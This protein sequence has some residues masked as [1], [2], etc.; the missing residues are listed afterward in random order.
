MTIILFIVIGFIAAAWWA[1]VSFARENH[2][3]GIIA[4][5]VIVISGALVG[6]FC[7]FMSRGDN[8]NG[9]HHSYATG[10]HAALIFYAVSLGIAAF[11]FIR[12][13]HPSEHKYID[14]KVRMT[15][16]QL[17]TVRYEQKGAASDLGSY[18]FQGYPTLIKPL[19]AW[20]GYK[21]ILIDPTQISEIL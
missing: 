11:G 1:G 16:G 18:F 14:R 13:Y 12:A 4:F 3:Q 17:L 8:L 2:A 19:P 15:N 7:N 10:W 5:W 21:W 9:T 20:D 6:I